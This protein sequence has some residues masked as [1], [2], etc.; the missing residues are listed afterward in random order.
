MRQTKQETLLEN[1]K[2][3]TEWQKLIKLLRIIV[4]KKTSSSQRA[5]T[6]RS[7]SGR[8]ERD[9]MDLGPEPLRGQ[10]LNQ[11]VAQD[12]WSVPSVQVTEG[13]VG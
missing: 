2:K 5:L 12:L 10:V 13:S 8:P 3:L 4:F 11:T 1:V 7:P 9:P 6:R